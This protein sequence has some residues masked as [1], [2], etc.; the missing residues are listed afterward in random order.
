MWI[1]KRFDGLRETDSVL[2][3]VL[4]FFFE[5]PFQIPPPR[6]YHTERMGDQVDGEGYGERLISGRS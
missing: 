3:D 6:A 4:E 1:R 5:I 2:L